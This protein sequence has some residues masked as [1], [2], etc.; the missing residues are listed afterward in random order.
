M[1][2][3]DYLENHEG[4]GILSTANRAGEVNAAV[5]ARPHVLEPGKVAFVMRERLSRANLLEN[6]FAH[7]LFLEEGSKSK[8][9]RL[10][11]EMVE[12][13]RDSEIIQTVSRRKRTN[14]DDEHKYL[15]K[16]RVKKALQLI[17]GEEVALN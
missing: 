16:F 7:Y 1:N 3:T 10:H 9:L 5:Y 13:I 4:L 12:E 2:L 11:L 15:V 6:R 17:C 8:G 14:L